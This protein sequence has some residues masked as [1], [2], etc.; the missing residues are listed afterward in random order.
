MTTC[1][2]EYG[3]EP[4]QVTGPVVGLGLPYVTGAATAGVERLSEAPDAPPR[5]AGSS[6]A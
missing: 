4:A 3:V 1:A 6:G 5:R 2:A